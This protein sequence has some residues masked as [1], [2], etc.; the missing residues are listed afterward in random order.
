MSGCVPRPEPD[1][2]GSLAKGSAWHGADTCK[3]GRKSGRHHPIRQMGKLRPKGRGTRGLVGEERG[4]DPPALPRAME[5]CPPHSPCLHPQPLP[6]EEEGENKSPR[7]PWPPR[8]SGPSPAIASCSPLLQVGCSG[9]RSLPGSSVAMV[10]T[11]T[12]QPSCIILD[13]CCLPGSGDGQVS[14]SPLSEEAPPGDRAG[15]GVHRPPPPGLRNQ[16]RDHLTQSFPFFQN[17]D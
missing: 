1:S 17:W 12:W 15:G 9:F 14:R 13:S 16:K 11:V 4:A 3:W 5:A 2:Q 6:K 8:G 7:R 10:T